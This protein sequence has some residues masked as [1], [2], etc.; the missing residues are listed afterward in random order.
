M[1]VIH[2][3]DHGHL[4]RLRFSTFKPQ[5]SNLLVNL[6]GIFFIL[7]LRLTQII[8]VLTFFFVLLFLF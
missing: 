3:I 8:I 1:M 7:N 6:V 4:S 2:L 5:Y